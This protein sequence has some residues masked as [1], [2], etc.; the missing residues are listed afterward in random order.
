MNLTRKKEA[1]LIGNSY[2]LLVLS[3]L[4]LKQ[5]VDIEVYFDNEN[6]HSL[7]ILDEE[8]YNLAISY[9]HDTEGIV[10][11]VLSKVGINIFEEVKIFDKIESYLLPLGE[12]VVRIK[13][14]E[15]FSSS[16]C[17]IFPGEKN[18]I[19][20]FFE[21]IINLGKEN[22]MSVIKEK[23]TLKEIPLFMKYFGTSYEKFVRGFNFKKEIENILFSVAPWNKI[24]LVTMAG[25]WLQL[26]SIGMLK[27]GWKNFYKK[28]VSRIKE[29]CDIFIDRLLKIEK[30]TDGWEI[31]FE[32]GKKIYTRVIIFSKG[33]WILRELT[34]RKIQF[35]PLERL[36]SQIYLILWNKDRINFDI[37]VAYVREIV[38]D[39]KTKIIYSYLN[40]NIVKLEYISHNNF[41]LEEVKS[42]YDFKIIKSFIAQQIQQIT[43]IN[44]GILSLWA[45]SVEEIKSNPLRNLEVCDGIY[46]LGD[47]GNGYFF[48]A[49]FYSREILKYLG[50]NP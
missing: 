5:G 7:H 49:E 25:Y 32:N 18:K 4:L 13:G 16:L 6:P 11:Y 9:L 26:D 20:Q 17:K 28:L 24:S 2:G 8:E 15:S 31:T 47:W 14:I 3:L 10:N 37:D 41:F 43:G 48:A 23:I 27:Y 12:N 45:H 33:R 19:E 22:W 50:Y 44:N 29:K 21:T 42:L 1:V 39:P 30:N 34:Q 38:D 40:K 35:Y 36:P 46:C